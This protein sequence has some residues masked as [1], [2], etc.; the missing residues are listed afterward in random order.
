MKIT[1]HTFIS[2]L[3]CFLCRYAEANNPAVVYKQVG[4][5]SDSY[6]KGQWVAIDSA[7]LS[8][9][10]YDSLGNLKRLYVKQWNGQS[11]SPAYY[12]EA[13]YNAAGQYINFHRLNWDT[14]TNSYENDGYNIY[15]YDSLIYRTSDTFYTWHSS[16]SSWLPEQ[17]NNFAYDQNHNQI[18]SASYIWD[19]P[20]NLWQ[21]IDAAGYIYNH[22][23][24]Y[25][26]LQGRYTNGVLYDAYKNSYTFD[27]AGNVLTDTTIAWN[28]PQQIW[29]N[30]GYT[31]YQ[32]NAANKA[33]LEL[34]RGFNSG[35]NSY[36][37]DYIDSSIYDNHNYLV[38]E[39][40]SDY[41][42]DPANIIYWDVYTNDSNGNNIRDIGYD[43][44]QTSQN[45]EYYHKDSFQYNSENQL[46]TQIIQYWDSTYWLNSSYN[47]NQY[48]NNTNGHSS[49]ENSYRWYNNSWLLRIRSSYQYDEHGNNIFRLNQTNQD[50]GDT[51]NIT[52][53]RYYY[54]Y[55]S[56]D[57]SDIQFGNSDINIY[58]NPV[59]S[60]LYI[61]LPEIYSNLSYAV[62]DILGREMIGG[63]FTS[64]NYGIDITGYSDGIYVLK[65]NNIS[66]KFVV[67]H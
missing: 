52:G 25:Q 21:N 5:R 20:L 34:E 2:L 36:Y 65:T 28:E 29:V 60:V 33:I 55:E 19:A 39:F 44:N 32:Y 4:Y 22:N 12:N 41:E 7:Q 49:T 54:Y 35:T 15:F 63:N 24:L 40:S 67:R 56:L 61:A 50:V 53:L 66:H 6:I 43:W 57:P 51:L 64:N 9:Y 30:S 58:P 62:Y 10:I 59:S 26:T 1:P 27:T 11:W 46:T 17:F 23:K 16:D 37:I 8:G 18:Y 42:S 47:E 38:Q 45:W 31:T 13:E 14:L 48:D 3:L